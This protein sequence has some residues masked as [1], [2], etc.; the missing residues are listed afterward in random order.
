MSRKTTAFELMEAPKCNDARGW[1]ENRL[2]GK[3]IIL[4]ETY[5]AEKQC[6]FYKRLKG[7]LGNDQECES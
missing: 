1:C 3:C 5:P 2:E 6:P 7:V 4:K